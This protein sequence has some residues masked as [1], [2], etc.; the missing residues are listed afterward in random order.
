MS[1]QP[2]LSGLQHLY[3][4]LVA[5]GQAFQ[6][7]LSTGEDRAAAEREAQVEELAQDLFAIMWPSFRWNL[8]T[9]ETKTIARIYARA[10]TEC[11]WAKGEPEC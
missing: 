10:L 3:D 8:S 7:V 2:D 11:G 9:E 5:G 1:D 6:L 4:K